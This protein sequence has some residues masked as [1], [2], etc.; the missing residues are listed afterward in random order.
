MR[1]HFNRA[2]TDSA[3]SI[4]LA[5]LAAICLACP[6]P[7]SAHGY[8]LLYTF[9]QA[10]GDCPDGQGP[11]GGLVEDGSGNLYGVTYSGGASKY[12]GVAYELE[13]AAKGRYAYHVIYNF[14]A[15]LE[16][17]LEPGGSLILDTAGN[18]YGTSGYGG[19]GE[20]GLG[21]VFELMP[22]KRH[23]KWTEKLLYSFCSQT[24][25]N[26]GG[27]PMTLTYAGAASGA[28]YDG[29]SPLFGITAGFGGEGATAPSTA[30]DVQP[31]TGFQLLH[32][33][34]SRGD[35]AGAYGPLVEDA[36]GN[37]YGA[38]VQ[39]GS[40]TTNAGVLY[41]LSPAKNSY[42]E[43]ILHTF[44]PGYP[45]ADGSQPESG[46]TMD[47]SGNLYGTTYYGGADC[48]VDG[49]IGCGVA[50]M[51]KPDGISSKETVLRT[52]CSSKHCA[53]G[54]NPFGPLL[55]D[56]QGN[57]FGT[58]LLGGNKVAPYGGGTLFEVSGSTFQVLHKFCHY[59]FY[60]GSCTDVT[61]GFYPNGA[62]I[63][64]G[65]GRLFGTTF[66]GGAGQTASYSGNGVVF[67]L[68]P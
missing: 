31:G 8:R 43:T 41:E 67:E 11:S 44:C 19:A 63:R 53:D 57:I 15:T 3:F 68:V 6:T 37:L 12:Y 35:G 48:S 56:A 65:K 50:F 23:D 38:T 49:D 59:P 16:D 33:F 39:G 42:T 51:L 4:S 2:V 26:D 64:D 17:A 30:Y 58:T 24:N 32:T 10:G 1:R 66:Y 62:L 21:T 22:N 45:C 34:G 28:L 61:D 20:Y 9:C 40:D 27:L 5:L 14:G 7:A 46:V 55:L 13:R 29:K 25:C 47:A 36:S 52:F 18:L 54:V 60:G